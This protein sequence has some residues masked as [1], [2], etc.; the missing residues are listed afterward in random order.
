MSTQS[1]T[2]ADSIELP[3]KTGRTPPRGGM[4]FFKFTTF[5]LCLL[6]PCID[7]FHRHGAFSFL[8]HSFSFSF[9][10]F[11]CRQLRWKCSFVRSAGMLLFPI[12][13]SRSTSIYYCQWKWQ[14]PTSLRDCK[15]QAADTCAAL[16]ET[17]P[18]GPGSLNHCDFYAGGRI[19]LTQLTFPTQ[20]T[21][22]HTQEHACVSRLS[23]VIKFKAQ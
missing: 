13:M 23:V 15:M 22:T 18:F 9:F 1:Q 8:A 19:H 17:A 4:W 2:T 3:P 6:F 16:L 12:W 7:L 11:F 14:E 5:S 20:P 21:H 10:F